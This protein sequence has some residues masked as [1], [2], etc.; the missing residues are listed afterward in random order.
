VGGIFSAKIE[1]HARLSQCCHLTRQRAR[2]IVA[3]S[4]TGMSQIMPKKQRKLKGSSKMIFY[5]NFKVV[6]I[7]IVIILIIVIGYICHL[8]VVLVLIGC[9]LRGLSS[10]L[11]VIGRHRQ[12][13]SSVF[14]VISLIVLVLVI[15]IGPYHHSCHS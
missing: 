6:V 10:S 4:V 13:S 14:L 8:S 3:G 12:L 1:K 9:L 11:S 7:I 5:F 2:E 15:I